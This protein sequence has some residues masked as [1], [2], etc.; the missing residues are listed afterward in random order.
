MKR[1]M[2]LVLFFIL[3]FSFSVLG[4]GCDRHREKGRVV[5]TIDNSPI[6]A[7]DLKRDLALYLRS[8]PLFKVTP[9]TLDDTLDRLIDKTLLIKEARER[10]LDQTDRFVNTIK[11]FWE[12][13][14]IRDL[15][16]EKNMEF[17]L[18]ISVTE[19]ETRGFYEKLEKIEGVPIMPYEEMKPEIEEMVRNNK[20]RELFSAWLNRVREET[21]IKINN[22]VLKEAQYKYGKQ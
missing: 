6:Y 9:Q 11:T 21:E 2:S 14:L 12:Q 16:V 1:T 19:E 15:M 3:I 18:E 4:P 10:K 7:K 8:D 17:E 5:A 13:T 22:N 20:K